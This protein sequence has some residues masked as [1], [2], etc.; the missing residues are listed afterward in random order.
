MPADGSVYRVRRG[1]TLYSIAFRNGLDYRELAR[2]NRIDAPYTIYPGQEI[3]LD[4]RS[5]VRRGSTSTPQPS[6]RATSV[7][8]RPSP[9]PASAE[10]RPAAARPAPSV[11]KP[12]DA[13]AT[14]A[15]PPRAPAIEANSAAADMVWRWPADRQREPT[16]EE[17]RKIRIAVSKLRRQLEILGT[18]ERIT[19][20]RARGYRFEPAR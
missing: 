8:P 2:E 12:A 3:R 15:V 17:K 18:G 6:T 19:N 11:A 4:G 14:P 7:A 1:D 16:G 10:S 9:P 20:M 5:P 13:A